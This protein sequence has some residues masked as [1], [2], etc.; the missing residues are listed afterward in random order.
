MKPASGA[1]RTL[2]CTVFPP[3]SAATLLNRETRLLRALDEGSV[4]R[5]AWCLFSTF[6]SESIA[7]G[8]YEH[9]ASAIKTDLCRE[10]EVPVVRRPTGGIPVRFG[11]GTLHV[12]L[13]L[14]HASV[15][16]DTPPPKILNR[17]SRG[18]LAALQGLGLD[19]AYTGR[20]FLS[21]N[22][23]HV[24]Y[25]SF[26]I[27]QGGAVLVE[28]VLGLEAP[29]TVADDLIAHPAPAG[30]ATGGKPSRSLQ[31]LLSRTVTTEEMIQH[32]LDGLRR[33]YGIEP[34][35]ADPLPLLSPSRNETPIEDEPLDG[36]RHARLP[37]SIGFVEAFVE[38]RERTL[39]RAHFRGDFLADSP[40]IGELEARLA[41]APCTAETIEASM[42]SVYDGARHVLLGAR[43]DDL[44]RVLGAAT[45]AMPS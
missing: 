5:A 31:D 34:S 7:L 39:T 40:G 9:P 23:S 6:D 15:W 4:E 11:P 22:G 20:E 13:L 16:L 3:S 30:F 18:L 44:A 35:P 41:G 38:L 14:P 17:Y 24:G 45:G 21:A 12:A 8:R 26:E 19:A 43:P 1:G 2:H 27:A 28:I 37:V 25:L 32:V 36:F 33:R 42:R 10:R 29:W